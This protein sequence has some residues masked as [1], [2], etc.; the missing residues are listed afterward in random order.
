M[1]SFFS[2]S[3]ES[4]W[5]LLLL[6]IALAAIFFAHGKMKWGMWKM[7]ASEELPSGMLTILRFLSIV[8]PLGAAAVLFGIF[9]KAAAWGFVL[10]MIGAIY[11]KMKKMHVPFSGPNMVGW[12][13]EFII[14]AAA[15][16]LA[17]SG[18]GVISF[19]Q[20]VWTARI[21]LPL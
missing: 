1:E 18:P 11:L 2:F 14:L 7:P 8:E 15:A 6:R 5:G 19:D 17:L 21:A 10:V 13:F 16:L 20:Y 9:T 3:G 12:E 4:E